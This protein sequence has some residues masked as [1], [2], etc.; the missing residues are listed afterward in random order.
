MTEPSDHLLR[1][2]VDLLMEGGYE[3]ISVRRV[4]TRAGVSIGAVQH[5]FPTKDAMLSAAMGLAS[6][7]FQD[8]LDQRVPADASPEQAL[9]A[10]VD[11]LLGA[12]PEQR[13]ATVLWTLRLARATVDATTA[14]THAGEWQQ[15]EDL[16]AGLLRASRPRRGE[17]WA[18][19]E[20]ALLLALADGLAPAVALEPDRM[21]TERARLILDEQLARVLK[22]TGAAPDA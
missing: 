10:V 4:A 5:H 20:A 16:L 6:K 13:P 8:R 1:V 12:E 22:G 3:G 11:E 9:R 18:R 21:P 17:H 15:V 19:Q 7:Q 14:R 2:V